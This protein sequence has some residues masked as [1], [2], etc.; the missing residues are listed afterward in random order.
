M[1]PDDFVSRVF[2][3]LFKARVPRYEAIA[4][5]YGYT[6]DGNDVAKVETEDD[7]VALIAA[8]LAKQ[9]D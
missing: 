3:Q 5:Q 4:K 8:A 6:I 1:P 7:F 9:T 2:P